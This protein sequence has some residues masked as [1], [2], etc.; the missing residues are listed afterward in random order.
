MNIPFIPTRGRIESLLKEKG[1]TRENMEQKLREKANVLIKDVCLTIKTK[2]PRNISIVEYVD[3]YRKSPT[4]WK[5]P[6]KK[7]EYRKDGEYHLISIWFSS[8]AVSPQ[9]IYHAVK[10]DPLTR[11]QFPDMFLMQEVYDK[12]VKPDAETH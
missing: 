9:V 2:N 6:I 7:V 3:S 5:W 10:Y 4:E 1:L 12:E 8:D 11:K